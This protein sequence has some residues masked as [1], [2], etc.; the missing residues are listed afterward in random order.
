MH[1]LCAKLIKSEELL[2]GDVVVSEAEHEGRSVVRETRSDDM[3]G[4]MMLLLEHL[5]AR[6]YLQ[7]P[8]MQIDLLLLG[9][10]VEGGEN[11]GRIQEG[12]V[13]RRWVERKKE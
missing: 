8:R 9:K 10:T 6:L 1:R 4:L 2:Y 11:D 13:D 12:W 3:R 7:R 5:Y